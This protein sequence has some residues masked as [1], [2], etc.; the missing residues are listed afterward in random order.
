MKAKTKNTL[1]LIG[2]K[3]SGLENGRKREL[4][5]FFLQLHGLDV[6]TGNTK[7]CLAIKSFH[8]CADKCGL[9]KV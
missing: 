4:S 8:I 5:F 9:F 7:C 3:E 1:L 6:A 2:E